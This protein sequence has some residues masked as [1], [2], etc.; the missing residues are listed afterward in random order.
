MPEI[1]LEGCRPEPLAFYLKALGVLR[2]VSEQLDPGVH[3]FWRDDRFVLE[4]EV[5]AE[6]LRRFFLERY[7]PTPILAPWNGGS[8][9]HPK[10][11]HQAIEAISGSQAGRL[12]PVATAIEVAQRVLIELGLHDKPEK[13]KKQRLLEALRSRWPDEALRALDTAVVLT[14]E[15]LQFPALTGTGWND[16]RLEFTRTFLERLV[17]LM[18]PD[19][20]TAKPTAPDLIDNALFGRP[21][22]GLPNAT[23][24]Q[25]QPAGAGGANGGPG[26][27]GRTQVNPWDYVLMLEGTLLFTAAATRRLERAGPGALAAPFSVRP[28]GS[29]YASATDAEDSRAELW[30]PL[31]DRPATLREL[32]V[33]FGEGRAK[34]GRRTARTGI[35]FARAIGGLGVQRGLSGF[36]RY[37]FHV[38]NGLSY[39][40]TPLGRFIPRRR[41]ELDLLGAIDKWL[42]ELS[43][44]ARKDAA[45]ASLRRAHRRLEDAILGAARDAAPMTEVLVALGEVE[46]ALD[47][48]RRGS[49]LYLSPVP[50]LPGEAWWRACDDGSA[51]Y[52]LATALAAAGLRSR[53]VAVDAAGRWSDNVRSVVW[54]P[55]DLVTNLLAVLARDD[56]EAQTPD[57]GG[58]RR[59]TRPSVFARADDIAVF[60]AGSMDDGRL[61]EL[62][63]GLSLLRP[64]PSHAAP[65]RAP[66]PPT[67]A[68]MRL[69]S[70]PRLP[71]SPGAPA[72]AIEVPRTPQILARGAAGDARGALEAAA[73]RLRGLGLIPVSTTPYEPPRRLRRTTAALAFPMDFGALRRLMQQHLRLPDQDAEASERS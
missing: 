51:E 52:R 30:V 57:P 68:L 16:G 14:T 41:P 27:A 39:F 66:L 44:V 32:E 18:E 54:A 28:A 48:S 45:P 65:G 62:A 69:A 15:G 34:V 35:D 63:R 42:A 38:R 19:T 29:G 37:G 13:D 40:A 47:R 58:A 60:L 59:P 67:F 55:R 5:D 24:G 20:G 70:V 6:G 25:F 26:F 46:A 4:T 8:G 9:F 56:L 10:D 31:W 2:L 72:D 3:A 71:S 17:D 61:E 11:N 36:V 50:W 1:V 22:A 23:P 12:A 49:D 33:L 64:L 43:F 53:L 21:I 73:R 7:A